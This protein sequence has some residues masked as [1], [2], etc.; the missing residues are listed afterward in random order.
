MSEKISLDSSAQESKFQQIN[1]RF[2]QHHH[3]PL[4]YFFELIF[5]ST[6]KKMM[7][8]KNQTRYG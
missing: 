7:I 4:I 1:F 6:H 5:F 2:K 8:S 3:F